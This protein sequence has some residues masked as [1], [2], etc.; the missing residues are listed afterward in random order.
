MLILALLRKKRCKGRK[1]NVMWQDFSHFFE[2]MPL[3][4]EKLG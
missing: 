3:F 2:K 1:K 4:E